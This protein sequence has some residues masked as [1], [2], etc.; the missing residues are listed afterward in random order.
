MEF[1][2]HNVQT[3]DIFQEDKESK[4]NEERNLVVLWLRDSS[5]LGP[6]SCFAEMH[7]AWRIDAWL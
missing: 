7:L 1:L 2:M 3:D 6:L 4:D 5:S